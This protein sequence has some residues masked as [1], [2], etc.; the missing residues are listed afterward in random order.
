MNTRYLRTCGIIASIIMCFL[1]FCLATNYGTM[2]W[3]CT[4]IIF[5]QNSDNIYL[6]RWKAQDDMWRN[7]LKGANLKHRYLWTEPYMMPLIAPPPPFFFNI[8]FFF[9]V[10]NILQWIETKYNQTEVSIHTGFLTYLYMSETR[11]G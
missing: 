1:F 7:V 9:H 2:S 4:L 10:H 11:Y 8:D 6:F 3:V 5:I